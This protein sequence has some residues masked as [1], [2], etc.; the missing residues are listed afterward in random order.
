[1]ISKRWSFHLWLV[2]RFLSGGRRVLSAPTIIS[3]VGMA[4]GVA[5]LTVAMGVVSGFED[6]L[7]TAIVDVF[8]DIMLVKKGDKPQVV[9]NI[10][11]LIKKSAPEVRYYTPFA[12]LQGIIAGSGKV[13]GIVIEGVDPKTVEKVLNLKKRIIQ[14]SFKFGRA[15]GD[16]PYAMVG[17]KLA[18]TYNLKIGDQFKGVLPSP[19][20][21]DSTEF[22]PR[23][24]TFVLSGVLDLGKAEYDDRMVITDLPTVQKFG[25]MNDSFTGIRIKLDD[26]D[27]APAAARR[28]N[29]DLGSSYYVSDWSEV[30]KNL[31]KAAAIERVVI[32]IV[33]S[34]IVLVASFNIASNLFV[35]VLKRYGDISCLR[36]MGFASVDVQKIF[37]IQGLMF[38]LVGT[39][40]GFILGLILC[41]VFVVA[42]NYV[43]LLPQETYRIDHVGVT[44][45][46]IDVFAIVGVSIFICLISSFVPAR[47]GARLDPV[48]GL[49]Y[50]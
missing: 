15:E 31:M 28:L 34:I 20:R 50:E 32:F 37:I 44:L 42:Q 10:T 33:I 23:V 29:L 24:M 36:A 8:G 39:V 45:R 7:K 2:Y 11:A 30:N 17:K 27:K 38:G 43:V 16:L 25:S 47:K 14:G 21:S 26:S 41:V 13:S 40:V 9:E 19:S 22:S 1:M 48:Q 3:L 46:F 49:R 6:T 5:S 4:L 12:D 35:S 18:K